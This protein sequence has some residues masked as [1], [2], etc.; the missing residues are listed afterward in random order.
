M[1]TVPSMRPVV[2]GARG[3]GA[4]G[5]AVGALSTERR[6]AAE[7]VRSRVEMDMSRR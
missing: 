5:T 1:M 2:R 3:G 6:E 7:A 4:V